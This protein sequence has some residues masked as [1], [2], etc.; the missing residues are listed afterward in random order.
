M[1]HRW[2]TLSTA[3]SLSLLA[4]ACDGTVDEPQI[5]DMDNMNDNGN[6]NDNT[7]DTPPPPPPL[8]G[9]T[10]FRVSVSNISTVHPYLDSGAQAIPVGGSS[11]GPLFPG[12]AYEAT[13]RAAPGDSLS[14][15]TMFVQSNDLFYSVP[16][17]AVPLFT[18]DGQPREIDLTPEIRLY[19][20]GTELNEEP[21]V[22]P[23]QAPRQAGP[24]T[25]A[26]DPNPLVRLAE[27]EFG[28]LP[29]TQE[30]ISA[31][32]TYE[33]GGFFKLRVENVSNSTTLSHSHGTSAVPLSPVVYAVHKDATPFFTVGE[34]DLGEGLEAVAEDGSPVALAQH[35]APLTGVTSPISP[36][37]W[38]VHSDI[39]AIFNIN[40][41][42]RDQGL[43]A[44]AEDGRPMQLAESLSVRQDVAGSGVFANIVGASS[45]S[46]AFPGQSYEF[47]INARPGYSLS[48][49]TMYIQSNDLFIAFGDA[50]L[51]LFN[52]TTPIS[53]DVSGQLQLWDA[54]T[55]VNEIDGAGP[56]QAPRQLTANLGLDENG[57]IELAGP[58]HP[59]AWDIVRVTVTPL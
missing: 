53:G 5:D 55:E 32:L 16:Q 33:G 10:R 39:G 23:N 29:M 43:E 17:W 31:V 50:G 42:D 8:P 14:F 19:D 25:G 38:A 4:V 48:L 9:E 6:D 51:E 24:N 13:F 54:G 15:A 44:I 12:N 49:A 40:N 22:G 21:G 36:G 27:D 3:L 28:N 35:L 2:I 34:E 20:A 11:P 1:N 57:T 59:F 45:P 7:V 52:G 41:P 56:N 18:P 58:E 30:V 47:E 26:A 46:P 37:A